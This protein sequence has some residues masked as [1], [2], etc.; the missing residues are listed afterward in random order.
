MQVISKDTGLFCI[1]L[2]ETYT[3]TQNENN[4]M[5]QIAGQHLKLF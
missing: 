2:P 3:H 4:Y 1:P 5:L